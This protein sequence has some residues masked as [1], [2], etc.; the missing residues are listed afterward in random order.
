M[1]SFQEAFGEIVN[2]CTAPRKIF[3]SFHEFG[4]GDYGMNL[5]S[6]VSDRTQSFDLWY[7]I[8]IA[9]FPQIF[10]FCWLSGYVSPSSYSGAICDLVERYSFVPRETAAIS[11][12]LCGVIQFN[13]RSNLT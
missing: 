6:T 5:V 3:D 11:F 13:V 7:L 8:C 4:I 1:L 12:R 10:V 2:F 9:S